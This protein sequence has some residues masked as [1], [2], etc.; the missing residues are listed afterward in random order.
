[1]NC[2]KITNARTLEDSIPIDLYIE[3]NRIVRTFQDNINPDRIIDA[4]GNLVIPGLINPHTH[5]DKA[6]LADQI[7][8]VSGT[9][10]EARQKML[11]SKHSISVADIKFRA[12]KV[13]EES[14]RY[15]VTAIRTHIDVDPT[16][17]LRGIQALLEL[18]TE[19][20]GRIDLQIVAFPQ[21]GIS[22]SIGTYDLMVEAL[23]MGADVVGGHLSIV[24]D[25]REHSQTVFQLAQE[26][27]RPVDIHV[28]FDI[29]R[30]YSRCIT[31]VDGKTYPENLGIVW[32]AEEVLN[33]GYNGRAAASHLCGLDSISPNLS[34]NV[35]NLIHD[36][37]IA[38]IALA[39]GNLFLQGRLDR[40]NVRRGVTKVKELQQASVRVTFGPDNIRDPFNPIGSPDM[41]L[42]AIL[43]TYA[44]QMTSKNDFKEV[45]HMC[46]T[47]AAQIMQLP[48]YGLQ[49]GCLADL[50]I[51][52]R[53]TVEDVLAYHARPCVTMKHGRVVWEL[54]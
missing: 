26:F 8:N 32:M 14:I 13:I 34:T 25:H 51:L 11:E 10:Q 23:R 30:D 16:I 31:R 41:I 2:V 29:D 19:Y 24:R 9:V 43:T 20:Q 53:A 5:L 35:V 21:E 17:G 45:L 28:D 49:E 22:E 6:G 3:G 40:C 33:R 50:V 1:M 47:H 54:S 7:T 52:D 36:A 12:G 38:V 4:R 27:N 44:C 48:D 18:K 46:T 42:N 15:G 39:P 37:N